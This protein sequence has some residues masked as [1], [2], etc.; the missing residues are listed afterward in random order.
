MKRSALLLI[1]VAL[2]SGCLA[3]AYLCTPGEVPE[4]YRFQ[5]LEGQPQP[6]LATS[7]TWTGG[8]SSMTR[9]SRA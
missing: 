6:E 2:L 7:P 9:P 5:A 1:G 4:E 3:P 8:R